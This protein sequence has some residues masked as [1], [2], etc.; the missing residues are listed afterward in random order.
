MKPILIIATTLGLFSLTANPQS[1][2]AKDCE[3]G[4]YDGAYAG[5]VVVP[6]NWNCRERDEFWYTDQGS[7][8]VPYVWFLNLEQA[9]STEKFSAPDNM[10]AYRYLPQNPS[11]LNPDGLPIGFTRGNARAN[12]AYGGISRDWLGVTCA[13]C[14]TGRIEFKGAKF[15]ID[16]GPTL[17]DFETL[18]GD[19]VTAMNA[20][21]SDSA[22]FD[23]FASAVIADSGVRGSGGTKDKNELRNQLEEVSKIRGA[24]NERNRGTAKSGKYGHGRLDAVGSIINE[25]SASVLGDSTNI[26]PADAPVSYPHIWDSPQHDRVQ[27]NGSIFNA[28]TGV[29]R[30]NVGEV[31][32]VFGYLG[33]TANGV[34]TSID[35]AA[36]GELEALLARLQSPL[37]SDTSLP[38]INRKLINGSAKK[39]FQDFCARCHG[40]IARAD[41]QRRIT[42]KMFPVVKRDA[43]PDEKT[44]STDIKMAENFRTRNGAAGEGL[45]KA[46]S[47][48]IL[49]AFIKSQKDALEAMKSGQSA[50]AIQVIE[51][52]AAKHLSGETDL[53]SFFGLISS[54]L[55]AQPDAKNPDC[56][57]HDD[58]LCYKARPLNGIWATAPYLHNGSVRTM[59]QLLLPSERRQ[60]TFQIGTREY[61]PVHM[62]FEDDGA[63]TFDTSLDGNSNAGHEGRE[64]GSDELAN[65]PER[66][67]ALLEYL[68]TL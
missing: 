4:T 50:D 3:S 67:D 25:I 14:H 57:P 47:G 61:D 23:R 32:G 59:R 28:G 63:F 46:I 21:L 65:D 55:P 29:L 40:T 36:L 66:L 24:W 60:K 53:P 27:W 22:K 16:G 9:G 17:G 1:S 48:A 43:A 42:V 20:T 13:A 10:D 44:V 58:R 8:I 56:F 26:K 15:I 31:L 11:K 7:Q 68:K 19:L 45:T 5:E 62:G 18:F 41:P 38:P 52:A 34:S 6:Q 54:K 39:D 30:R 49:E 12:E 33:T 51:E 64:Y 2:V 37:W 35:F